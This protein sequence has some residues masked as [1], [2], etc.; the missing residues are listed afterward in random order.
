MAGIPCSGTAHLEGVAVKADELLLWLSARKQGTW[1]QFKGAAEDLHAPDDEAAREDDVDAEEERGRDALPLYQRLRLNF[2]RL[3]HAEFFAAGCE[4]GW[5]VAPPVL[6]ARQHGGSWTGILCGA[7]SR[8]LLA[9]LH[10]AAASKAGLE[11]EEQDGAPLVHRFAAKDQ[12]A[13]A[14]LAGES[15]LR[16]QV[17]APLA[18]LYSLPAVCDRALRRPEELPLGPDWRVEQFSAEALGWS[19]SSREDAL[20]TGEGVFRFRFRYQWHHFLCL[21]GKAYRIPGQ[22]AKYVLL[23]RRRRKIL[24]Y[25]AQALAL[26]LPAA[27]RPPLLVER[28]LILCTGRLPAFQGRAKMLT[29]G[30]IPPLVA[31]LAARLLCQEN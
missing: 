26:T 24:I 27:C 7:R 9:R 11:A 2:E 16:F 29:Y 23:R 8:R 15:G 17:E 25:D 5:R 13:L 14:A 12:S 18:I 21:H 30:G 4:E 3:G 10:D 1:E 31:Q 22:I 28:A 19:G 20:R 6:A